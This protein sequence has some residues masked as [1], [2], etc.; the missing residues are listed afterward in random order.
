[1][2]LYS[3]QGMCYTVLQKRTCSRADLRG[4]GTRETADDIDWQFNSG[5]YLK[6]GN[7]TCGGS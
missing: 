2:A 3:C 5:G 6:A 7:M 1:M 4:Q